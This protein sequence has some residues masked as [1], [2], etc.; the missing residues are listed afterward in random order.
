L[1]SVQRS[2]TSAHVKRKA[3][4]E[5]EECIVTSIDQSA[6]ATRK[7]QGVFETCEKVGYVSFHQ[8]AFPRMILLQHNFLSTI[9]NILMLDRN[10]F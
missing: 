4:D 10:H 3:F 7:K 9:K 2:I 6:P 8:K 5:N 1:I